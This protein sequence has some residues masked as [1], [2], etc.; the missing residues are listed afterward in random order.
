MPKMGG[1]I[2][3]TTEFVR[4]VSAYIAVGNAISWLLGLSVMSAILAWLTGWATF[5][6][7]TLG[8]SGSISGAIFALAIIILFQV[9][10]SQAQ[11]SPHALRTIIIGTVGIASIALMLAWADLFLSLPSTFDDGWPDAL[12]C[13]SYIPNG[14]NES[15]YQG[16]K[17]E[18]FYYLSATFEVGN[19]LGRVIRY[20]YLGGVGTRSIS[21]DSDV[22]R[23]KPHYRFPLINQIWFVMEGPYVGHRVFRR[24]SLDTPLTGSQRAD[25]LIIKE[26]SKIVFEA[27]Y[28]GNDGYEH[29]FA[30]STRYTPMCGNNDNVGDTLSEIKSAGNGFAIARLKP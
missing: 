5:V 14:S 3:R 29:G 9:A 11:R 12:R 17:S 13:T 18:N 20:D 16:S 24:D 8:W 10:V 4:A 19:K 27:P 26:S 25:D 23:D 2:L 15:Q 22:G 6:W 1:F 30:D 21:D 7:R 28:G